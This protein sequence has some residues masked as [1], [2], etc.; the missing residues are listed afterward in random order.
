MIRCR[1]GRLQPV[2]QVARTLGAPDAGGRLHRRRPPYADHRQVDARDLVE[3]AGLAAARGAD[4][5]DDGVVAGQAQP[6]VD[7]VGHHLGPRHGVRAAGAPGPRSTASDS[8]AARISTSGALARRPILIVA[9]SGLI[10]RPPRRARRSSAPGPGPG[11]SGGESSSSASRTSSSRLRSTSSNASTRPCSSARA[12]AASIRTAWSPNTASSRP[13]GH[14]R[15]TAGDAHLGSGQT[16]GLA[17]H[18]QHQHDTQAVDAV[19]QDACG[20]PAPAALVAHELEDVRPASPRTIRLTRSLGRRPAAP[21]RGAPSPTPPRRRRCASRR[22]ASAAAFCASLDTSAATPVCSASPSSAL[23]AGR[24][25]T[26]DMIR[27]RSRP[28]LVSR[29]RR[30][31][32]VP[33]NSCHRASTSPRSSVPSVSA[34]R[35]RLRGRVVRRRDIRAQHRHALALRLRGVDQRGGPRLSARSVPS[36]VRRATI[37]RAFGV[38]REGRE[39]RAH[40]FDDVLGQPAVLELHLRDHE[41]RRVAQVVLLAACRPGRPGS[42]RPLRA[43]RGRAPSPARSPAARRR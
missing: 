13:L 16:R 1:L 34:G 40:P 22:A 21:A 39:P 8:A 9:S 4:Q 6:L 42:P 41:H 31:S 10:G 7:P 5:R 18:H 28:T 26:A 2:H 37:A 29:L 23:G 38:A 11:Q 15:R 25:R 27:S 20:R 19:R 24:P 33:T 30:N 14:D 12:F 36:S 43:A 35:D 32:P 17:E 3:Q